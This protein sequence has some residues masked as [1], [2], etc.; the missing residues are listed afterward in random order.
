MYYSTITTF[1]IL[2]TVV[3]WGVLFNGTWFEEV[4]DGWANVSEHALNSCFAVFEIVMIRTDPPP[5]LHLV[6]LV[7][8]LALY[9]S[10]AYITDATQ[11]Y[12]PYSFLNP[13]I[14][15]GLVTGYC[16]GILAAI[17]VIFGV[18]WVLIWVRKWLTEKVM[19]MDGKY[20]KAR[21]GANTEVEPGRI[22][23]GELKVE[24]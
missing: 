12:Y 15:S 21:K 7:L 19:K 23:I 10:L 24:A 16:F 6:A 2:V 4:Y 9:L 17:C 3:F 22:G 11:G 14:G 8:I 13:R 5:A 20:S 18:V 1:P